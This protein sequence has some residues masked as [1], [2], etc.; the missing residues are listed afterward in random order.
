MP[1]KGKDN[2]KVI[3]TL[4]K[5]K[6]EPM[7][8]RSILLAFLL[9]RYI[10]I[11]SQYTVS[12][13]VQDENGNPLFGAN[14]SLDHT[15]Y[16]TTTDSS[17][18]FIIKEVTEGEYVL[19]VLYLGFD[20]YLKN[21]SVHHSE[22]F[23][24]ELVVKP[25]MADEVIVTA[26]RVTDDVPVTKSSVSHDEIHTQNTG[27]DV[28]FLLALTPSAVT[29]SDAGAGVGYTSIRIRG[30]DETGINVTVN[31]IPV[32]DAESHGVY[33]VDFPDIAASADHIQIQRGVGSSTQG[34]GAFGGTINFQ[35]SELNNKSNAEI[36]SD[37]GSFNT[38]KNSVSFGTG[39]IN[40][41]FCFDVRLSKITSNGYIDRAWSNLKSYYA[42]GAYY[43]EYSLL[44]LITFSGVE[45]TYQAWDGVPDTVVNKDRTFNPLGEY[46]DKNG[47]VHFYNNQTDNYQQDNYQILFS[48][49]FSPYLYLNTAVHFTH[50]K[51]YYEEYEQNQ[52][53]ASYGLDTIFLNNKLDT[54]SSTDLIRRQ[55]LDNVFYGATGSLNY[56][57]GKTNAMIGGG[58]NQYFGKH[59]GTLIWAQYMSNGQINQQYYYSDGTKTDYNAFTKITSQLSSNL[60]I[61]VDLQYRGIIHSIQ[62]VNDDGVTNIS[63][64]HQYQFFNPKVG[65][66][67]IINHKNKAYIYYGI[68]HREPTWE[69]FVD[70]P[71]GQ[72][73]K[74]EQLNDLEI[75]YQ[76]KTE[77]MQLGVNVYDMNYYDQLV[78]TGQI[79]DVG[80]SVFT[81][82]KESYRAGVE[83][84]FAA[85]VLNHLSWEANASFS[86]NYITNF[87]AYYPATDTSTHVSDFLKKTKISFSP[88]IVSASQLSYNFTKYFTFALLSKYVGEQYLDNTQNE[89]RKLNPYFINDIQLR[90]HFK[91]KYTSKIE[92]II[93]LN[94][95]FDVKYETN[96]WTY[97]YTTNN[98]HNADVSYF[99]Q[100]LRNYMVG[101]VICF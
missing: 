16:G 72:P 17:G 22:T 51:G 98:I 74:P 83:I 80:E 15:F 38:F 60:S 54:I 12:G 9:C 25:Y 79:N 49:Q 40:N 32:N 4:V 91:T 101:F 64:S 75:G 62:G 43:S 24:I 78:L 37:F 84:T 27:Q 6:F 44:K 99:P 23:T 3:V 31:G 82:V 14:V 66:T 76:L 52:S 13:N 67:Y 85:Q 11:Y 8:K 59:Y 89:D 81:N 18:T 41:H 2:E 42:S 20:T 48:H 57:F 7:A 5:H 94:N 61:Y 29:T 63:Q 73:V 10:T 71:A 33:W 86:Q 58:W 69:D 95:I 65:L 90:C 35:T 53:L 87:T 100:A 47:G 21:I 45:Q 19:K 68:S 50:G 34:A 28:P 93:K 88:E 92:A 96:G 55:W 26:V 97:P 36:T 39:L 56:K 46:F 77:K 70:A 1:A 30:T